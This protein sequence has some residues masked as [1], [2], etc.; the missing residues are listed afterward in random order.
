MQVFLTLL[1]WIRIG[2][3]SEQEKVLETLILRKQLAM[4][5]QRLGKPVRLSR[6]ERLTLMVISAMLKTVSIP[7]GV[8]RGDSASATRNGL[9][10]AS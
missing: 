4:V 7:Q 1:E 3:L 10:V 6:A 9:Q 8:A 5:E 2:Y